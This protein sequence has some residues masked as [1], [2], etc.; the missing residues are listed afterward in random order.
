MRT[1]RMGAKD[2]FNEVHLICDMR[3]VLIPQCD[4]VEKP[5]KKTASGEAAASGLEPGTP[6]MQS[7]ALGSWPQCSVVKHSIS[8]YDQRSNK[9]SLELTLSKQQHHLSDFFKPLPKYSWH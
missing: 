5:L 1:V 2:G 6:R 9:S 3:P 8:L 7:G 4:G